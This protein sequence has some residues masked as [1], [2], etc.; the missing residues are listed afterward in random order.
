MATGSRP[1][2]PDAGPNPR[3]AC[4]ESVHGRGW[5]NPNLDLYSNTDSAV[6]REAT[7]AVLPV[8]HSEKPLP[9]MKDCHFRQNMMGGDIT[10]D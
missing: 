6:K 10:S 3:E 9:I 1:V 5:H 8:N 2:S 7:P 4:R